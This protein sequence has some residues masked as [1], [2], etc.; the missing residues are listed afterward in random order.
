MKYSP[1]EAYLIILGACNN[2]CA[3]SMNRKHKESVTEFAKFIL[4]YKNNPDHLCEREI[5]Y[6]KEIE[7]RLEENG[8]L[9]KQKQN[10]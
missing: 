1:E 8:T 9:F 6:G 2:F 5:Y 4:E 7:R 10:D 3:N